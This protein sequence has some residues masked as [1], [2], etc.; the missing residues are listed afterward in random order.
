MILLV[1][2]IPSSFFVSNIFDGLM[3][4]LLPCSLVIIND[5]GA[6]L[7]GMHLLQRSMQQTLSLPVLMLL[8]MQSP[9]MNWSIPFDLC[10]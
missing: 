4:F 6:Y 2:F 9:Y 10:R 5:I 8:P 3:W 1:V 7:F